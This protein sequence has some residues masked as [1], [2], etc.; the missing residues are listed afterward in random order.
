[1]PAELPTKLPRV[2]RTGVAP[3]S[4]IVHLGLGAFF[5]AHGAIYIEEA[6]A[7]SGGDWGIIGVSLQSP[8]MRDQLAPQD[9][10]YT[11]QELGPNGETLRQVEAITDVLVAREDP[12]AVLDAMASPEIRIVSLTVTE[13][14]YCHDPASGQLN[15]DHPDIIHDLDSEIPVSSPGFLVR[16][17]Q[18]RRDTG[19]PPFTVLT[20]DNLP[21]NGKLVRNIVIEFANL[22]DTDLAKWI[23]SDGRFPSTMVDRIVPATKPED[24]V[25]LAEKTEF[26]DAAP[27]LHEP[28]RQWAVEDD[29]VEAYGAEARPDLAAVGVELVQDVTPY[30][31]MKLRM[32]NG[33]HSA[34]AYLGYLAGY[35]TIAETVADP[36]MATYV[37]SLWRREI[38]PSFTPP[39]EVDLSAYASA[40]FK[41]YANPS[42]RHRTWQIAMDGSQKLPQRI[43]GT[44]RDNLDAGHQSPGLGTAIAAWMIYVGGTDLNGAPID[45]RDPLSEKLAALSAAASAPGEKVAALLGV[46]QI[47]NQDLAEEIGLDLVAAYILL[48]ADGVRTVLEDLA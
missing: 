16:A 10:V 36:V 18:L 25:A 6:M 15:K 47:F 42:I 2:S 46:D 38:I 8:R 3:R 34:L 45:V 24:I 29:F 20:C 48:S 33:T 43:L 44:L 40:L 26:F 4:G 19:L 39:P 5:R 21:E 13:K 27:V 31:H 41:R 9:F 11:A 1:M 30:E 32:L 7:A 28:F 23:E 14:G 12:Q 35:E 22:I 37:K 17:L